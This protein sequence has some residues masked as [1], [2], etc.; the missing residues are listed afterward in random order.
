MKKRKTYIRTKEHRKLMS[1]I[2]QNQVI[3]KEWRMN[4]S[5]NHADVG[6]INNPNWKG[7]VS[8][9]ECVCKEC[10]S[11]FYEKRCRIKNGRGKFCSANCRGKWMSKNIRGKNHYNYQG[12]SN[13]QAII[14]HSKQYKLWR[15]MVFERD[16]FTCVFCDMPGGW[17]KELQK[18]IILNADHIFPLG[19]LIRKNKITNYEEALACGELWDLENGRTLCEECHEETPTYLNCKMVKGF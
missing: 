16:G 14:R 9:T 6:G 2:K 11:I 17:S 19:I 3:T 13:I 1:D 12:K 7:G 10:G 8:E 5:L 15:K 18:K 4:I